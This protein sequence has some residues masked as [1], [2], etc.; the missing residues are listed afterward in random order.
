M[1]QNFTVFIRKRSVM[2]S[3]IRVA[4]KRPQARDTSGF[5]LKICEYLLKISPNET[6]HM[7]EIAL[8]DQTLGHSCREGGRKK[9]RKTQIWKRLYVMG[10]V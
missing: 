8:R 9:K 5:K 10:S 7:Y 2:G 1:L 6:T 4:T 3:A